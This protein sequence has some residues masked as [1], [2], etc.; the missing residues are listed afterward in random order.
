[1]TATLYHL[2]IALREIKPEIWRTFVIDGETPF[3]ELHEIIQIVMGWENEHLYKFDFENQAIVDRS[4]EENFVQKK[5]FD[6]NVITLNKLNLQKGQKFYYTY[7]FGDNWEH[8]IIV[9]DVEKTTPISYPICIAGEHS[10]PPENC[11]GT[12]GYLDLLKALKRPQS[13]A[14]KDYRSWLG[15]DFDPEDFDL[16]DINSLIEDFTDDF[17]S[18]FF[19]DERK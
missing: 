13:K 4:E 14:Y 19:P 9:E 2:R 5:A 15:G 16:L 1:M 10:C 18:E 12:A 8:E 11:G 3:S 7:D 17:R 6:S